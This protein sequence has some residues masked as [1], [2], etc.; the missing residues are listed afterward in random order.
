MVDN[1]I[2]LQ[3][4][5]YQAPQ[6]PD[7]GTTLGTATAL[8]TNML[9]QRLF[10]AQAD[11]ADLAN[12][13]NRT[14]QNAIISAYNGGGAAG[15]AGTGNATVAGADGTQ[16]TDGT[17][18]PGGG[19][20]PGVL[21]PDQIKRLTLLVPD[22]GE[23]LAQTYAK[24]GDEQ[25]SQQAY[26]WGM[27]SRAAMASKSPADFDA[28]LGDLLK[29]GI[30]TPDYYHLYLG[31]G[32]PDV[33]QALVTMGQTVDTALKTSGTEAG[34]VARATLPTDLTK[35][36]ATGDQTRLTQSVAPRDIPP[37]GQ[38][39][40]PAG[41]PNAGADGGNA[42]LGARNAPAAPGVNAIT[43][44][45][46]Q[47][48]TAPPVASPALAP[49]APVGT[50]VD[51]ASAAPAGSLPPPP[52][53]MAD[54]AA[55][56]APMPNAAA[57]VTPP[58]GASATANAS[59]DTGS[60]NG[61]LV[62]T[63]T[64]QGTVVSNPNSPAL[65]NLNQGQT[66][67]FN[68]ATG[69]DIAAYI[70]DHQK[71]VP[72]LQKQ[73]HSIGELREA[74]RGVPIGPGTVEVNEASNFLSR[75][76]IDINKVLPNGWQTDPSKISVAQ[77]NVMQL[78]AGYA[79]ANFPQRITNNDM[80]IAVN[81]VPN[82]FTNE[83][84]IDQLMDSLES[85][86]RIKLEEAKFLRQEGAKFGPNNP[87][88]WTIMDRWVDHLAKMKGVPEN[89]KQ[90]YMAYSDLAANPTT[91]AAAELPAA[92]PWSIRSAQGKDGQVIYQGKDA[93]GYYWADESGKRLP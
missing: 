62:V 60:S 46:P 43:A 34:N 63:K 54:V 28:N 61:G 7:L 53:N 26:K 71:A 73:L 30:I 35:I 93:N 41:L 57:P 20:P 82:L 69:K 59:P 68:E 15:A 64:P 92:P 55:G 4:R 70:S 6:G 48:G 22:L 38:T 37:G 8:Q 88:D 74:V 5:P 13:F 87:P 9:R 56:K 76:G 58:T 36:Q 10:S 14:K 77:K 27:I 12:S 52:M 3:V 25:R 17:A 16:A 40:Y 45:L 79:Q 85:V 75:F 89:V 86:T 1:T 49:R 65:I 91:A 78:A 51:T 90:S 66:P 47:V 21:G 67:S 84:A 31:R 33:L 24:L 19:N 83:K 50:A 72:G 2:A 39:F 81:S 44:P 29:G 18:A 80:V 11:A 42:F 23:K 32:T